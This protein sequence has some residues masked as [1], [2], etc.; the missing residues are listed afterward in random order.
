M[1][2]IL[3]TALISLC[4]ISSIAQQTLSSSGGEAK[5]TGGVVSY[6]VG[7]LVYTTI[8]A[9]NGSILQGVQQPYE[10]SVVTDIKEAN[11][12]SL[13]FTVY[14]NPTTDLIILKTGNYEVGNLRYQLYNDYGT[15][16]QDYKVEDNETRIKMSSLFPAIYFLKVTDNKKVIRTFKIIKN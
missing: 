9:I 5:G 14:P 1:K 13:E 11:D 7:Q 4:G 10:I 15:L 16:L 12:V 3:I 2:T 6:T 8:T